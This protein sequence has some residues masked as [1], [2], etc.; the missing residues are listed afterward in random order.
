MAALVRID[1]GGTHGFQARIGPQ[2]GYRS[3]LFSDRKW[4]GKKKAKDAALEWI[5]SQGERYA[6]KRFGPKKGIQI[7]NMSGTP[8]VHESKLTRNGNEHRYWAAHYSIGPDG[9]RTHRS[10]RFYFGTKRTSEEARALAE[11]FR[12]KWVAAFEENGTDGVKKF[13][14][15]WEA[16]HPSP[17][18]G[19][20]AGTT[21]KKPSARASSKKK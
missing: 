20:K 17:Q 13:F 5:E 18:R 21:A 19:R 10:R 11:E 7:N 14:K 9:K 8:G 15:E 4:G 16:A 6:P 1:A 3:K 12:T 2:T